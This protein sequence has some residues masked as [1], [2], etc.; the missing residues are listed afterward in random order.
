MFAKNH[1]IIYNIKILFRRFCLAFEDAKMKQTYHSIDEIRFPSLHGTGS[2]ERRHDSDEDRI[3]WLMGQLKHVDYTNLPRSDKTLVRDFLSA[4]TGLNRSRINKHIAIHREILRRNHVGLRRT[5]KS[6]VLLTHVACTASLLLVAL[7]LGKSHSQSLFADLAEREPLTFLSETEGENVVLNDESQDVFDIRTRLTGPSYSES[8]LYVS[9]LSSAD[10]SVAPQPLFLANDAIERT[11]DRTAVR[12]RSFALDAATLMQRVSERRAARMSGVGSTQSV[13]PSS[14]DS[15]SVQPFAPIASES[16]DRQLLRLAAILG[17]GEPGQV[18]IFEAGRPQWRNLQEMTRTG[19]GRKPAEMR[20][21]GGTE[22]GSA[23]SGVDR[24]VGGGGGGRSYGGGGGGGGSRQESVSSVTNITQIVGGDSVWE[25]SSGLV[26]LST[27]A[28]F[29]G[30]GTATPETELEVIGTASASSLTVSDL[31]DCDNLVTD[32]NG[33]VS[34]GSGVVG[35]N[36]VFVGTTTVTTYDGSFSDSGKV[37]YDAA[38][39]LCDAEFT[40]SH[41]C[42]TDEI[43][44]TIATENIATLFSGVP[45]AWIAEGPPGFTAD[46][47]DCRGWTS[48]AATHLGPWWDFSISGGG[49]GYLTNCSTVKPLAC[50]M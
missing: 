40:G 27:S 2:A 33:N 31:I 37:G 6:R 39:A 23:P 44:S 10:G 29:V 20:G 47:N 26:Y 43:L 1:K 32:A 11:S 30:I 13:P 8:R 49:V 12:Q 3:D 15:P 25:G 22:H 41:F 14:V 38:N 45:D 35:S 4:T 7:L 18:L 48:N 17:S 36:G 9:L 16:I 19:A 34:C 24:S 50:C 42:R 21:G 46:S 5:E 28:D